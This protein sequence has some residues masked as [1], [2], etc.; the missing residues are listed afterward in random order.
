MIV[1][2]FFIALLSIVL[3]LSGCGL[4][5]ERPETLQIDDKIY[6]TGFYGTLYP[7][8]Y[9]LTEDTLQANDLTLVRIA[10]DTFELYHADVGPYV[11]GTI[12]CEESQYEQALA[13]YSDPGNYTYFCTLGVDM[14]DGTQARTV[15][16]PNV[17]TTM[18]DDLLSF[19]NK[20]EYNPFDSW[21]NSKVETVEL[22]IPDNTVDTRMVFY[23]ESNDGLFCSIKG[24]DYYIIDNSLYM[25][26][27]YD[28]GHGK[29]EK[30]IAVKVPENISTYFVS[31]M[32]SFLK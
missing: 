26:Y 28:Y 20:S 13:Y 27:Q 11:D 31:F 3:V 7:S 32:E 23:K 9:S 10:H 8:E 18:F 12:Y 19:A 21:Q 25:V 30:L 15:E 14:I 5:P 4:I 1:R 2:K 24:T 22:P 17:D 16:L 6:K 29:Y